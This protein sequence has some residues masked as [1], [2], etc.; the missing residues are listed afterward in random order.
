MCV[1]V[2]ELPGLLIQLWS[3]GPVCC[4]DHMMHLSLSLDL[5]REEPCSQKDAYLWALP[6]PRLPAG[7]DSPLC[8]S[9]DSFLL[10][11]KRFHLFLGKGKEGERERNIDQGTWPATQVCAHWE[12]VCRGD[13]QPS[14][15]HQSGHEP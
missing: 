3:L 14:E 10:F 5:G 13:A 7:A 2:S 9:P 6:G 11:F 15:L 12:L 8:L 4:A 1:L